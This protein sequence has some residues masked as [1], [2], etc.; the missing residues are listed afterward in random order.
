MDIDAPAAAKCLTFSLAF[1]SE[2][3]PEYVGSQYND[4]FV[5]ELDGS[6]WS[7]SGS[8]VQAPANFAFDA[9]GQPL[10][11]NSAS[12]ADG[13]STAM[14]Y[15]GSTQLLRA[16]TPITPGPPQLYLSVFDVG[17]HAYDTAVLVDELRT[18]AVSGSA[19]QSGAALAD[20]TATASSTPGRPTASTA[21]RT[22]TT[23]SIASRTTSRS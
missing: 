16:A 7:M 4:G 15:D 21:T 2:E 13:S 6:T 19:C 22:A 9:S 1:Y 18:S 14:E 12:F 3:Y 5:A 23:T 20:A 10:T 8:T 17:D 11:V